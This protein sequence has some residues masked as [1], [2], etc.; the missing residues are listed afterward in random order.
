M[1]RKWKRRKRKNG[2]RGFDIHIQWETGSVMRSNYAS[3]ALEQRRRR[4]RRWRWRP[5]TIGTKS[6]NA[7]ERLRSLIICRIPLIS[8]ALNRPHL[9]YSPYERHFILQAFLP[10]TPPT[11]STW[12]EELADSTKATFSVCV[13]ISERI[14]QAK[15]WNSMISEDFILTQWLVTLKVERNENALI[16]KK[17]QCFQWMVCFID[18]TTRNGNFSQHLLRFRSWGSAFAKE[19]IEE[20]SH[21]NGPSGKEKNPN[22]IG[23][24]GSWFRIDGPSSF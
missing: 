15:S 18:T 17:K 12:W 5:R 13:S 22:E 1:R 10:I 8:C 24:I 2:R 20:A 6:A 19:D 7:V 23:R 4:Q 21:V 14:V 3:R 9:Q 16:L 11:D